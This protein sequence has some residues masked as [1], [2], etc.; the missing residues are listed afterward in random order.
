MPVD[1]VVDSSIARA[2]GEAVRLPEES[3]DSKGSRDC[4]NCIRQHGHFLVLS[5][6]LLE[7]WTNHQSRFARKWRKA[8]YAR[9]RV[10]HIESPHDPHLRRRIHATTET[11]RQWI[12]LEKD[13]RLVEAALVTDK[14]VVSL[15]DAARTLFR[16]SAVKVDELRNILW[17]NPSKPDE[18]VGT[19]IS[20]GCTTQQNR[21]LGRT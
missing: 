21:A 14:I 5:P 6:E 4:L 2:A 8:M 12:E 9:R 3:L 16:K 1:L 19:W 17:A 7:E 10:R 15:D 13:C 11:R 18:E 20:A